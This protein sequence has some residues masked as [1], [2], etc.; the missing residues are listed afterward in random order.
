MCREPD[1]VAA[2]SRRAQTWEGQSPSFAKMSPM[3]QSRPHIQR[4]Q[5]LVMLQLASQW[6]RRRPTMWPFNGGFRI[7]GTPEVGVVVVARK[8]PL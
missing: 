5:R 4:N 3:P 2:P 1:L 8:R 7:S 6:R